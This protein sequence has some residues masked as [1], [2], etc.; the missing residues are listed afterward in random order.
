MDASQLVSCIMPTA[1]RSTFVP[2][3]IG[4]FL[5]AQYEPREL[6]IVDDGSEPI[7]DL[8]PDDARIRYV[9]LEHRTSVGTK[10]NRAIQQARGELICHWDDDDWH[11]PHRIGTL[12]TA[13]RAAQAE[14][15]GTREMLFYDQGAG[16]TWLYRYPP[17]SRPWLVGGS[18]LYTREFWQAAPFPDRQVGE[19]SQ[20]LWR[21]RPP[22]TVCLED[23]RLYVALI[24][25]G[26]TCPKDRRGPYWSRWS[27]DLESLLGEE[28]AMFRG[29]PVPWASVAGERI[30]EVSSQQPSVASG[31]DGNGPLSVHGERAWGEGRRRGIAMPPPTSR[32]TRK[33]TRM[34]L[35]LGC[36]DTLLPGYVNVDIVPGPGVEVADLREPWPWGEGS[37]AEVR[38]W[39]VVEHL[40]DRIRTMNELWRV[41]RPGGTAEL[42]VPTTDGPGAFQDPTHASFW[43][44][45]SFLYFEAGNPYR[46]RFA[47]HYGIAAKFRVL[48]ER[49]EPTPDGPRLT[50]TLQ[51][52]KP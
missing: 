18:L 48:A 38:A 42:A 15:C 4:Y 24:H 40:P 32:E 13:L 52:L 9:R 19:D 51:A 27:G 14:V 50:I 39:D 11:A 29:R 5:R 28:L 43:N 7:R 33:E 6:V 21:A 16:E 8:V 2:R 46:E 17:G 34:K 1:N 30:A 47:A 35:N 20:F 3:A 37:V 36:C 41:L 23:H 44:R 31:N 25:S 10:R 26:N 12:V 49:T 22:R 45:R